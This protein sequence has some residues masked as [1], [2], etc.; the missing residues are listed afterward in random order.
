MDALERVA[1]RLREP[2]KPFIDGRFVEA[3]SGR[4]FDVT[5]PATGERLAR[6]HEAGPEDVDAAV[7]A[8]RN[9][10]RDPAW[11]RMHPSD[12]ERLLLRIADGLDEWAEEVGTV[13]TLNNGKTLR[14]GRGDV[15]P[16]ADI[17]RYYAG[18]ARH[19]QGETIPVDGDD[20]VYTLREPVGVCGQIVPWNYPLLM[21]SWKIAPAIACGNTVVLK[22]SEW[23][24]LTALMLAEVCKNAGV[25]NGVVNVVPGFGEVAGAALAA[26]MDVDKVAFTGSVDT[27]RKLLHASADSNLKK[28]SLELGGKSPLIVLPD[29]DLE[30]AVRAAFWGIFA[31]K[32][33][34]CSASSRLL[35]HRDVRARLVE[36][37]ADTANDMKVGDPLDPDSRMGA[38]V[39]QAQL[40]KVL[41]YI[42]AGKREGA[43]VA[44][45]G[46]RITEGGLARGYF[47]RP[48]VFDEVKPEMSIAREEI[49]GPVLSV[50]EFD[51]DEAAMKLA[52]DTTYG[53]VAG[54]FTRDIGRAHRLAR[55]VQAGVVWINRWNGFDSAAPF[56]GFKQ[57]GWGREMGQHAL[58]HYT[59]TKCVWVAL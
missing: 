30:E 7:A 43:K 19:V 1:E 22:P 38:I 16:S 54:L 26:H 20:F 29:A 33:E 58:E 27:A 12:R 42:E 53:L 41:R 51:D 17:F 44:A 25:P 40:D 48:T 13:E 4:L 18:W 46:E 52:N 56:G 45:G 57:S 14:E 15:G 55:D 50:L 31:N 59:Q 8:A 32:G 5:N 10:F 34:V 49:F 35:A 21:A 36:A 3:R 37:L 39:S 6:V 28:L 23:T 9:A 2:R 47:V 11:R 24:P